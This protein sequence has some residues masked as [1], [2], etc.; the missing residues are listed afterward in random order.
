MS[1]DPPLPSDWHGLAT[2]IEPP[3]ARDPPPEMDAHAQAMRNAIA[4]S[5]I[6][7]IC[8]NQEAARAVDV[9]LEALGGEA[10]STQ[11]ALQ[12][13]VAALEADVAKLKGALA[14]EKE[15]KE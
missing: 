14:E 1:R 11:A 2:V 3:A 5:S 12:K 10:V 4:S 15:K 13:R 8:Q 7:D 9:R 6:G